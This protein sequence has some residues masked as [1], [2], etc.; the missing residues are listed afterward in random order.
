MKE[1]A[2][3]Y[4]FLRHVTRETDTRVRVNESRIDNGE[5]WAAKMHNLRVEGG[6]RGLRGATG[7]IFLVQSE[8]GRF[9][10]GQRLRPA[11]V[12]VPR[13]YPLDS[14]DMRGQKQVGGNGANVGQ[15]AAL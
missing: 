4:P 5:Y 10:Y 1:I 11:L 14:I 15:E 2:R 9:E 3:Q 12:P 7:K 6:G 13:W 8:D